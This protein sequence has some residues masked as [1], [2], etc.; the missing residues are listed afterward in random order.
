MHPRRPRRTWP[1]LP[2][3]LA[4]TAL[5][6]TGCTTGPAGPRGEVT[7]ITTADGVRTAEVHRPASAAPGAALV[8][9]LHGMGGDAEGARRLFGW[10]ALAERDGFVVAYPDGVG[11]SWNAGPCCGPAHER[12]VDDV[13]FLRAL[14]ARLVEEHGLDPTRVYAVGMSNGAMMSYTWACSHP[15]ELAAVGSVAGARLVDCPAPGPLT[16]VAVHGTADRS[17]PVEGG[18]GPQSMTGYDYPPL[19]RSLEPF[20]RDCTARPLPGPPGTEVSGWTCEDGSRVVSALVDGRGHTWA[21]SGT[22][23]LV[24]EHMGTARRG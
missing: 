18:V 4:L 16:V 8:V 1:G 3:L 2:A 10:D 7:R 23:A 19:E 9:V 12:G 21:G 11:R 22:A 15:G 6:V 5:L 14:A 13:G 24:W 20:R 17:V